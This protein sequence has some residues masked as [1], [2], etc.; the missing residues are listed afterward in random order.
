MEISDGDE[1]SPVSIAQTAGQ[2]I[3]GFPPDPS[4]V[5]GSDVIN[6]TK[7]L[8]ITGSNGSYVGDGSIIYQGPQAGGDLMDRPLSGYLAH[9]SA[10]E[11][12]ELE[13]T[14]DMTTIARNIDSAGTFTVDGQKI[15][16]LDYIPGGDI[17]QATSGNVDPAKLIIEL[18]HYGSVN[19]Q[20]T[21]QEAFHQES[22][23]ENVSNVA[24]EEQYQN[25]IKSNDSF[26]GQ[27]NLE[28]HQTQDVDAQYADQAQK[29][30]D[31][32]SLSLQHR[33]DLHTVVE[34]SDQSEVLTSI[35]A[36][37]Q[38][39]ELKTVF[40]ARSP[41]HQEEQ[42]EAESHVKDLVHSPLEE[43]ESKKPDMIF[44]SKVLAHLDA[45]ARDEGIEY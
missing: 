7:V 6:E 19:S 33:L 2:L 28:K 37:G 8:D 27:K 24:E 32:E 30:Q 15:S 36:H 31:L 21:R 39:L 45:A 22:K 44:R 29:A 14:M 23:D 10:A 40:E 43:T 5:L 41:D 9:S 20:E 34:T 11:G 3:T 38:T 1:I 16:V 4:Q 18:A 25:S 12:I 35:H 17:V 13:R 42:K 26:E